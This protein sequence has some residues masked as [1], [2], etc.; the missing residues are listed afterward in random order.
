MA[1]DHL[2]RAVELADK[3]S[4]AALRWQTR[5]RLAEA[6]S[7]LNR[8]NAELYRQAAV[9]VEQLAANLH[10]QHLRTCFL[11]SPLVV[12]LKANARSALER[13]PPPPALVMTTGG[14]PA[15]LTVREVEVLRL[16]AGGATNRQIAEQLHLSVGTVN[17]HLTNILNKIGCENRTA[18]TA[19]A[20]QHGLVNAG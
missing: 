10:D 9:M 4:H 19:F 16:V 20:L 17:S 18:A 13:K 14:F 11:A 7:V 3:I 1:V 5:L 12:E 15:G 8:P 2:Q 6:Y